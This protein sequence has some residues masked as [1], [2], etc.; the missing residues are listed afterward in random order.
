MQP[1]HARSPGRADRVKVREPA[2]V[3]GPRVDVYSV[4]PLSIGG[5]GI[6]LKLAVR[7]RA[8]GAVLDAEYPRQI[9]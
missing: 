2:P 5:W 6:G 4:L 3:I 1:S 8:D 7:D 9:P